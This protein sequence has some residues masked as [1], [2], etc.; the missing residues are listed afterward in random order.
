LTLENR[1]GTPRRPDAAD[2]LC[3]Q[4]LRALERERDRGGA[5]QPLSLRCLAERLDP[6]PSPALLNK[7]TGKRSFQGRVVSVR[8]QNLDS[9]VALV[10]DLELLAGSHLVLEFL[11][12]TLRTSSNQAF[13]VAQLK[14]KTSSKLQKP[15]QAALDRQ[16]EENRLP[17]TV[18]WI[19]VNRSK[20]LFL[21]TDV[22]LARDCDGQVPWPFGSSARAAPGPGISEQVHDQEGSESLLEQEVFSDSQQVPFAQA[23]DR[24][25]QELDRQGGGPNLVSLVDLRRALAVSRETFDEELRRL[26]LSGRYGLSAAEGRFGLRAEEQQAGVLEDGTLLLY[27]SRKSS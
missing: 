18:G 19:T 8:R 2:E 9:P 26:R 14:A 4:L 12:R 25:F 1:V 24:A 3:D 17:P 7:A 11:L 21:L 23:F 22:R 10:E 6:R 15:L 13:S 27:V 20:K 5:Y 16:I